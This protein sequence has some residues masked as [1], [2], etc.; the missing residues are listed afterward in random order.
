MGSDPIKNFLRRVRPLVEILVEECLQLFKRDHIHLII[1]VGMVCT[2]DDEQ[3][4]IVSAQPAVCC[5]AEVT[6][7][8]LLAMYQE[9]SGPDLIAVSQDRHIHEGKRGCYVPAVVRVQAAR[10]IAARGLVVCVIVLDKL[11][12]I[13]RQRIDHAT[14]QRICAPSVIFCALC[15]QCFT[16]FVTRLL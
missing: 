2:R 13:L 7:M 1:E 14:G 4:F 12:C 8:C 16:L 9:Y 15:I 10:M 6:G 5:F 3:F 11:R